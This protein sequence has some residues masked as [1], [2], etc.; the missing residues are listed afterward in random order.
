[1]RTDGI[2]IAFFD[3]DGTLLTKGA[4]AVRPAVAEALR[5]GFIRQ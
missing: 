5:R 4:Q 1:M 3:I 2:R